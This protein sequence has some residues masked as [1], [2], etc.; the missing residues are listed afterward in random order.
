MK[1]SS[2]LLLVALCFGSSNLVLG[3]DGGGDEDCPSVPECCEE[4]CCGPNSSFDSPSCSFQL[5]APGFTGVYSADYLF[6]CTERTCCLEDCCGQNTQ[7]DPATGFCVVPLGSIA[8]NVSADLDNNDT[9]DIDL[10]G[11]LI[12]LFDAAGVLVATRLTDAMGN[13][14]FT[15]LPPGNYVVVQTNLPD[16]PDDVSDIDN[17]TDMNVINVTIGTPPFPPL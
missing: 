4:D 15:D 10:A 9:G 7:W 14:L 12:E 13:Y 6:G 8:G 16:F 3:Q 5:N 11:S 1:F 17:S 2:F